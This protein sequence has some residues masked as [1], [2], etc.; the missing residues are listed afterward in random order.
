MSSFVSRSYRSFPPAND[1]ADI[2]MRFRESSAL[3]PA[4][5]FS[6]N[7]LKLRVA[8][9]P[10]SKDV[11]LLLVATLAVCA[12]GHVSFGQTKEKD[13]KRGT[14]LTFETDV[15]PI[16]Q[17]KCAGCHNAKARKGDL[18][19]TSFGGLLKGGESG[20]VLE[21]KKPTDGVLYQMVHDELMP[22]EGKTPLT[23]TERQTIERWIKSGAR[24]KSGDSNDRFAR[25]NQHDVIPIIN[26]R[27]ITCHG[28]RRQEGGLDLRTKASMLKGGKSGP[29]MVLGDPGKSL[30]IKKIHSKDMPPPARLIPDGV[31]PVNSA[32]LEILAAW[33]RRGAPVV[34]VKPDVATHEP[35][36]LVTNKDRKFWSFQ[37][38]RRPEVPKAKNVDRVR[39]PIDAFVLRKLESAGL[40]LSNEAD[41][42][43][44]V[45]RVA[46]DLTG[47]PPTWEEVEAFLADDSA[48]AYP[49]MVDGYLDSPRY[50][51]RWGQHWL[52][53]AGYADSEGKRSAD[54]L[55]PHAWRYRDYV[56]RAFNSDKPYDQ[57]LMEQIA[58]DELADYESAEVIT[59]ELM[60]NLV[61][62]GFL[63]MAPDGTGSDIV[64]S[65]AERFEVVADEIDVFGSALLGLTLNCA[66]CHSHKYDP[67]P[68]RD[69][70]RLAAVF[71]GAYDEHDWLKPS[72][73]PGQTKSKKP[74]R[75]LNFVTPEIH[76][77]WQVKKDAIDAEIARVKQALE[78]KRQKVIARLRDERLAKL[79][80]DVR[81][82]VRLML[83]T[84]A[85]KRDA[86]QQELAKT[87]EK[88]FQFADSKLAKLDA[89]F[90]KLQRQTA[91][92]IKA[93]KADIPTEPSIR[94]LWDRGVPSLTYIYRRGEYTNPGRL[95]G[96]GVPVVLTDGKTP[97]DVK[98]PWPGAKK[99][100]RR[101]ALAKWLTDPQHPLTA[102]V[103]ANRIWFHHFD[104]GI[105]ESLSNFGNMGTPPTHPELLDWLASE[106]VATGWSIKAMHRL[107]MNSSTYRQTS[108]TTPRLWELDPENKRYSRM[109]LRRM[110]AEVVRD[111]ILSVAGRLNREPFGEPDPVEVRPDGLV[112]SKP[113]ELG[114]RRAIYVQ[115]RRKEM[116]TIL[117]TFDLPQMN[118]NCTERPNS[119]V[120]SQALLLMNNAMIREI[121][122][123]FAER[124]QREVG[125]EPYQQVERVYQLALNRMPD[126]NEKQLG[127]ETL[128]QLTAVWKK[129]LDDKASKQ[130]N[131]KDEKTSER[132]ETPELLALAKF[133]HTIINSAAFLYVD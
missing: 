71:K 29:V 43:T 132:M 41:K 18:D 110:D 120:A 59:D 45:R 5:S 100:G 69:Y 61:A 93:K 32:E 50:G 75:V 22:P 13:S 57:F 83:E 109:P 128:K 117:E 130:N 121:S 70:Y 78:Q 74:G 123:S 10:H 82:K 94:A 115:H 90:K 106:F 14:G 131:K 55:R 125:D 118:P 56:I 77:A 62:T 73:V 38:P 87:Y 80:E 126:D 101:L 79:P 105:V 2:R 66:K 7:R 122:Q 64:N 103:M 15:L 72:F 39:R 68:Q 20:S 97:F 47:L 49:K 113:T 98:P 16:V 84:P 17:K 52:D 102:R 8:M 35:D 53:L 81:G 37:P 23:K 89:E 25:I 11:R 91:K 86:A 112:V 119:T 60:D 114:W 104:R 111:S 34:D 48:D 99:S 26:L 54:P 129:Y 51:E 133:C 46:F 12:F 9:F 88:Q 30:M 63:R 21:S 116:P 107:I 85:K 96:P 33:I 76:K 42:L 6:P 124:V 40:R 3:P 67:I 24:S 31:R 127:I 44:L 19:L 65:V 58:G 108:V 4:C 95:V 1:S 27:C 36:S 92:E 28:L